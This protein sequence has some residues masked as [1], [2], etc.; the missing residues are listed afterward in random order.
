MS[1]VIVLTPQ[2]TGADGVSEMTRQVV[3]ALEPRIGD[4]VQSLE[5]WS[6][7]DQAVTNDGVK[8][9]RVRTA[10]GSRVAFTGFGLLAAPAA[11]A[12][13]LVVVLHAHLLPITLPLVA[14]GA[15]IVPVLL[16]IEAWKPLGTLERAAMRRAWRVAAISQ[17]TIGRFRDANPDLKDLHVRVCHPGLSDQHVASTELKSQT[18]TALIAGR[19]AS[20]ERYKGHD[21][22][23]EVWSEVR[24]DVPDATLVIAGGGD[25][26]RRLEEK[27]RACGVSDAVRF[28][29]RVSSARLAALYRQA[30][31]FAM[32]SAN[33]GFGIVYA[34]AMRAGT[35]CLAMR[36]AAE[37]IITDGITG[38]IVPSAGHDALAAALIELL[39]DP[40]R[41]ARMG[42]AAA[43]DVTERFSAGAFSRRIHDL[44]EIA[45]RPVEVLN[46][47]C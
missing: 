24:Q 5:V 6:L 42:A 31:I 17:H 22:L 26:R 29:G 30:T 7:M 2:I 39:S 38:V 45:H 40:S 14:T 44:L 21:Q 37:E 16:G 27:T 33:E 10:A 43:V 18:P 15:R 20:D 28:E 32:P 46:A 1:S 12:N 23:I 4:G 9:T 8:A 11:D 19:M 36:G 3:A 34:E 25:D 41:C 13:T 47:S 35:P